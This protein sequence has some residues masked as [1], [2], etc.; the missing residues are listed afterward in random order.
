[1]ITLLLAFHLYFT[2]QAYIHSRFEQAGLDGE[3]AVRIAYCES[4][5]DTKAVHKNRNGSFDKGILQIND[6]KRW[7]FSKRV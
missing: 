2:P 6:I 5:F 4:R 1:M 3:Q 7:I